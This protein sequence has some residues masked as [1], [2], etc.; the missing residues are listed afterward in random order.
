MDENEKKYKTPAAIKDTSRLREAK[1]RL[2]SVLS[3]VASLIHLLA[4]YGVH[5]HGEHALFL[6]S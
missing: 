2:I 3:T 5:I 6:F 1:A 4:C